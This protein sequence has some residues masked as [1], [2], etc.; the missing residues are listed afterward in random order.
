MANDED[1]HKVDICS[2]V[3]RLKPI[4]PSLASLLFGCQVCR[5][6]AIS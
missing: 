1:F 5:D 6:A 2:P 3:L 4:G